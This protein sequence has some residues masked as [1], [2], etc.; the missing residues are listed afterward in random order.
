M[1]KDSLNS[2][3]KSCRYHH[4]ISHKNKWEYILGYLYTFGLQLQSN[5]E[6][7]YSVTWL[8]SLDL[9]CI[10][11]C[12]FSAFLSMVNIVFVEFYACLHAFLKIFLLSFSHFLAY[13]VISRIFLKNVALLSGI[14]SYLYST[15]IILLCSLDCNYFNWI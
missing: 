9:I 13:M 2:Y 4:K 11:W 3:W 5:L 7:S 1:K 15:Q 8:T 14:H 12:I 6:M 10:M